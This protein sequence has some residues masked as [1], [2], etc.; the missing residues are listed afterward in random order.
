MSKYNLRMQNAL[1]PVK[2]PL[3]SGPYSYTVNMKNG[4]NYIHITIR[5]VMKDE[6]AKAYLE[7]RT[8]EI[9]DKVITLLKSKFPSDINTRTGLETIKQEIY[10]EFNDMFPE[11]FIEQSLTKDRTPVKQILVN[12]FYI[13]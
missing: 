6:M 1:E 13:Q 10:N 11:E 2:E 7:A 5:L 4:V 9:D 3:Y 12:E 8:P